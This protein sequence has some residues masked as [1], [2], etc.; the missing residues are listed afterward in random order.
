MRR[1]LIDS[2]AREKVFTLIGF[3]SAIITFLFLVRIDVN[4]I[5]FATISKFYSKMS[6][7][8]V[9]IYF[10]FTNWLWKI[11]LMFKFHK[12]P[13]LNGI[14][15]G[16]FISSYI[17][18]DTNENTV[19]VCEMEIKQT[20]DKITVKSRFNESES[21]SIN[22]SFNLNE[23][24]GTVVSF[25]YKN[26]RKSKHLV[27]SKAGNHTGFNRLVLKEYAGE[28]YLEGEYYSCS[29]RGTSGTLKVI[30]QNNTIPVTQPN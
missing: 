23:V 25:D 3:L 4:N 18:P 1:Y 19:G 7:T 20:W 6:V 28:I 10:I 16:E 24:E 12:V 26:D 15:V 5:E 29:S 27:N 17:N 2:G 11:K 21:N 9:V 14:W 8:F 30:K 13:N 22:V